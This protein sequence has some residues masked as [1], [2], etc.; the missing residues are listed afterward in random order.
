M[1]ENHKNPPAAPVDPASPEALTYLPNGWQSAIL[2]LAAQGKGHGS[3]IK[4][5]GLAPTDFYALAHKNKV[6]AEILSI[7]HA[8]GLEWLESRLVA[9]VNGH[10][11]A[12]TQKT[13]EMI[14][15]ARFSNFEKMY[16]PESAAE[17]SGDLD[18]FLATVDLGKLISAVEKRGILTRISTQK[19]VGNSVTEMAAK[20]RDL[21][22]GIV[23]RLENG[24]I[25]K[26]ERVKDLAIYAEIESGALGTTDNPT[27]PT[28]ATLAGKNK[29]IQKAILADE[30]WAQG[31]D[32]PLADFDDDEPQVISAE[33]NA[34]D[35]AEPTGAPALDFDDP[36]ELTHAQK[37][38]RLGGF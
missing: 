20:W 8:H 19:A 13:L 25:I 26:A 11:D 37:M 10:A 30:R 16:S 2:E 1:A 5:L 17:F 4:A 23:E 15:N 24:E 9:I 14:Y 6:F 29:E 38:A 33:P 7:A 32:E 35:F 31:F 22:S 28:D 36:P 27:M 21:F 3:F 12:R 34:V 18:A